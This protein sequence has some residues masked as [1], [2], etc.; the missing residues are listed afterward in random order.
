MNTNLIKDNFEPK[1]LKNSQKLEESSLL[2]NKQKLSSIQE[3]QKSFEEEIIE[4]HNDSKFSKISEKNRP[5]DEL[6]ESQHE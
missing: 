5:M 1:E 6:T 4:F 2:L 3:N